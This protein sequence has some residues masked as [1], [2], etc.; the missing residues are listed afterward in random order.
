MIEVLHGSH[1]YW[2]CLL[3][4]CI[5]V[6]S[7]HAVCESLPFWKHVWNCFSIILQWMYILIYIAYRYVLIYLHMQ[8]NPAV[9]LMTI[10]LLQVATSSTSLLV[11]HGNLSIPDTARLTE[12]PKAKEARKGKTRGFAR[13]CSGMEVPFT[14]ARPTIPKQGEFKR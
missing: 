13:K 8:I 3:Y 2:G 4:I 14:Y 12:P 5:F 7:L 1:V 9:G 6:V 10:R 11:R